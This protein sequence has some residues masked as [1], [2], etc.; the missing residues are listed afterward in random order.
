MSIYNFCSK[1]KKIE[2]LFKDYV[3]LCEQTSLISIL[4]GLP[5]SHTLVSE[6]CPLINMYPSMS[7]IQKKNNV[8]LSKGKH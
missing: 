5:S 2:F 6:H 4:L 8:K 1:I 7:Q 3:F